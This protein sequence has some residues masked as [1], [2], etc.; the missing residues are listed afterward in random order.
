MLGDDLLAALDGPRRALASLRRGLR[1]EGLPARMK[2]PERGLID[3]VVD[4][5]TV[6]LEG[7]ACAD[8]VAAGLFDALRIGIERPV[9]LPDDLVDALVLAAQLLH[10]A[11]ELRGIRYG[12]RRELPDAARGAVQDK[13]CDSFGV[14]DGGERARQAPGVPA[15]TRYG[16]ERGDIIRRRAQLLEIEGP[17]VDQLREALSRNSF[18]TRRHCAR[19]VGAQPRERAQSPAVLELA[20]GRRAPRLV[21]VA[22]RGR[23]EERRRCGIEC[24]D[25][26]GRRRRVFRCCAKQTP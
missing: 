26:I 12:M 3:R 25:R 14:V 16:K 24:R 13:S 20:D 5:M 15:I 11:L 10:E 8:A 23:D 22:E 9:L 1:G 6:P 19:S 18:E 21:R 4:P 17:C 2:V 7:L